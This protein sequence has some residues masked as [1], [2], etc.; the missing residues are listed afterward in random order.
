MQHILRWPGNVPLFSEVALVAALAWVVSGWLLPADSPT[1]SQLIPAISRPDLTLPNIAKL[2]AI[3][4]FGAIEQ[5]NQ[6]NIPVAVV[7]KPIVVSRLKIKLLGTVVS[8]ARAAAIIA[9]AAGREQRVF[10][11]GDSIQ[12]GVTLKT[13]E[14]G[15]IVVDRGGRLERVSLA[16]GTPLVSAPMPA[17]HAN[18]APP[19]NI[20]VRRPPPPPMPAYSHAGAM[21]RNINR[22]HLQQQLKNFPALLS[23]A[24]VI[25]RMVNGKPS[26]FTISEI[27]PGSL[28]QQ[29]GLRNG[30]II[31]SVNGKR[32]TDASQAMTM[33]QTL[34]SAPALDLVLIRGGQTQQVHYDIR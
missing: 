13:V 33:Y 23:Q 18:S 9:T 12:P 19:A 3:P 4:L 10:F 22:Q 21:R 24:R 26:G 6:P 27:A 29:A 14:A 28:Y 11:I 20:P 8:E 31:L 25:P 32:I 30:D 1:S 7:A 5:H 16:K 17:I 34:K 15:A 2:T